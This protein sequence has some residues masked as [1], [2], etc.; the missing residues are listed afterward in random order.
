MIELKELDYKIIKDILTN[1]FKKR[2]KFIDNE[3]LT[4]IALNSKGDIRAAINDLQTISELE[5]PSEILFSER[6]KETDIFNALKSFK[7]KATKE[8]LEILIP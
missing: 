4:K 8:T 5:K 3:I 6:N 1:I 2:K 7:S